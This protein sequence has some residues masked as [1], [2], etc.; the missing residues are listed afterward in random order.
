MRNSLALS[1]LFFWSQIVHRFK[2]W[3]ILLSLNAGLVVVCGLIVRISWSKVTEPVLIY[4]IWVA[5]LLMHF[6]IINLLSS[7]IILLIICLH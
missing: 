4:F 5:K 6:Q 7:I 1:S 3:L 2:P